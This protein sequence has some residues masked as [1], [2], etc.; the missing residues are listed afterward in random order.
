[1]DYSTFRKLDIVSDKQLRTRLDSLVAKGL[2]VRSYRSHLVSFIA[3]N[4]PRF[5]GKYLYSVT[6]KGKE[7]I[8]IQGAVLLKEPQSWSKDSELTEVS[9]PVACAKQV[10]DLDANS[11]SRVDLYKARL[12]KL[13]ERIGG[14]QGSLHEDFDL[15]ELGTEI[16][17]L[18]KGVR[19]VNKMYL[20][21]KKRG[22]K[23]FDHRTLV[24]SVF[25][26]ARS[27]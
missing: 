9:K 22:E 13:T 24:N 27:L 11:V 19:R 12:A 8:A 26:L 20:N 2:L 18:G 17:H 21:T 3:Y 14:D 5:T 25:D 4:V 6:H 23:D 10:T 1:V 7:A 15:S 16:E